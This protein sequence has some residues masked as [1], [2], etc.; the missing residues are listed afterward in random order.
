MLLIHYR[1]VAVVFVLAL[2]HAGAT[3]PVRIE[4]TI[5]Q[6]GSFIAAGFDALRI[7]SLETNKLIRVNPSENSVTEIPVA[8]PSGH[9]QTQVW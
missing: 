3:E 7:M 1:A 4:A 9:L 2:A 5:A 8:G 6:P